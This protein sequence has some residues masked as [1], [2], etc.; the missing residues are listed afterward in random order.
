MA[1]S[2]AT[3]MEIEKP[4]NGVDLS[5]G[6]DGGIIKEILREGEGDERPAKGDRV[7]VHYVG[8][9]LDGSKFD[10]SRDRG[11]TF[12]FNLG[13]GQVIKGWDVGVASMRKGEL[14]RL[15]CKAD[16]AYGAAGSPPK[17]PPNA[18]LVFE[19]ELFSWQGEDV[20]PG[21]DGGIIRST[22]AEGSG[23][24][25][26]NDYA[27]VTASF[28][29]KLN[30]KVLLNESSVNFTLGESDDPKITKGLEAAIKKMKLKE[31]SRFTMAPQYCYGKEGNKELDIPGDATLVYEVELVSFEKAKA[32]YEMENAE[33]LEQAEI[34]KAKGTDFFK[35][36]LT[37]KALANY[38]TILDYLDSE[39]TLD[40][41]EKTR[42]DALV[43]AA[44]L[45]LAA[46]QLKLGDNPSVIEHCN[47]ALEIQ[48]DSAKAYFRRA[49]AHQN[50]K[51]F[52]LA[53]EDY[54]EVIA[55]EPNNKAAKNQMIVC[56]KEQQAAYQK[57]KKLY[58]NMFS[59]VSQPDSKVGEK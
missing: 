33:K 57:E 46:C 21:K 7:V 26:P 20:S 29:V 44:R 36:G 39:S 30:G 49:Q 8:T 35:K 2:E 25:S 56:K 48:K 27:S 31:K 59:K 40:G 28:S 47:E 32:V 13:K 53:I 42:R 58:A 38:N 10:S 52:D 19:V 23:F 37:E 5:E 17:I 34:R 50:R 6:Q 22:L 9:L 3:P 41:E 45:N 14:A 12:T 18:T 4:V 1:A 15:T 55:L 54:Q 43:L 51:D 16:F 24:Q 11:D